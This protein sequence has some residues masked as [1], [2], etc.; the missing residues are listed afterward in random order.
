MSAEMNAPGHFSYIAKTRPS[1]Q[2][3]WMLAIASKKIQDENL[4]QSL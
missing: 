4:C 3:K 1:N 2:P